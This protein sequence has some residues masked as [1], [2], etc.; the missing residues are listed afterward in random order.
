MLNLHLTL[1]YNKHQFFN[2]LSY[3]LRSKV[4][5]LK[6]ASWR[7]C[8]TLVPRLNGP[9]LNPGDIIFGMA[10][11]PFLC[12]GTLL[13]QGKLPRLLPVIIYVFFSYKLTTILVSY[14]VSFCTRDFLLPCSPFYRVIKAD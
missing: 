14:K 13:F 1:H 11:M 7:S 3:F 10:A 5:S 6:G 8:Q 4:T 2:F 12:N 9:N